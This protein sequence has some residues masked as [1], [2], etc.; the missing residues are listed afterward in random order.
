EAAQRTEQLRTA[1]VD[2]MAHELKTPL[3]SIKAATTSLLA[4]PDQSAT[5]RT[6]LLQVAD[7]EADR[8]KELIDSSLEM[9]QLD[10]SNLQIHAESTDVSE[11]T[12]AAVSARRA[13]I[14]GRDVHIDAGPATLR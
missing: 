14:D 13:S 9:A 5:A 10:S 1:L 4:N 2:A 8:L 11:V 7:E 6:E 12:R 3:T